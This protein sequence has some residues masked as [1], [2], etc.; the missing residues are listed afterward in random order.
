[1]EGDTLH[2]VTPQ[3]VHNQASVTLVDRE[4]TEKLNRERNLQVKL[5][6]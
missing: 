1:M 3:R 4:L 6:R 2:Y 5:P